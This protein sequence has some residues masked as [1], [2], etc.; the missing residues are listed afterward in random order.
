MLADAS[1]SDCHPVH[2]PGAWGRIMNGGAWL[3]IESAPSVEDSRLSIVWCSVLPPGSRER[4][5][6]EA[7]RWELTDREI[8][9]A[10]LAAKGLRNKAIAERL[11][12]SDQTVKQ[13]LAEAYRKTQTD[14]RT[15]LALRL[16]GPS[17]DEP[18][19]A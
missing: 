5:V 10:A 8:E 13:Q 16:I 19:T 15:E 17:Q 4:L 9:V 6:A 14:G 3:R 12:T 2:P 11:G 1:A 7:R 18:P